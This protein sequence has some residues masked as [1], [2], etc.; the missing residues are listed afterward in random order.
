MKRIILIVLCLLI[1]GCRNLPYVYDDPIEKDKLLITGFGGPSDIVCTK[2]GRLD[3]LTVTWTFEG[4]DKRYCSLCAYE[5]LRI[6][7]DKHIGIGP[8]G[9]FSVK[10]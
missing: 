9:S 10:D 4:S 5:V 1:V 8:N 3:D 7:L 6:Y 2:H